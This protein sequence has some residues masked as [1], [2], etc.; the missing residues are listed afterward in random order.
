MLINKNKRQ[1]KTRVNIRDIA[2]AAG[3]SIAS[4]S[5]SL[6]GPSP[7][8]SEK[9]RKMILDVCAE[10]H[11]YPNEHARRM[12][13][14]MASS[15]A[16]FY[17]SFSVDYKDAPRHL[18]DVNFGTCLLGTQS[19]LEKHGIALVLVGLTQEYIE[20][21]SH[22]KLCR[23][24]SVDGI[25]IWGALESQKDY[26][27]ELLQEDFSPVLLQTEINDLPCARVIADDAA[28]TSFLVRKL[29]DSGHCRI[30]VAAPPTHA[31]T[32]R[33]RMH[34]I[35]AAFQETGT[36][37]Y[38]IST[39]ADYGY[40]FGIR[41]AEE[42]LKRCSPL[43]DAI[44][45]SN[46]NAAFGCIAYLKEHGLKIPEDISVVGADGFPTRGELTVESFATPAYEIGQKGA[47]LLLD[48]IAGAKHFPRVILPVKPV[49]GNTFR[50]R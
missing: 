16:M 36:Q 48:Q 26:I 30:A 24:K 46:D 29:L 14:R 28:G 33:E 10:M 2:K 38:F 42:I 4:V 8:L 17:P 20:K 44:V 22:L 7:Y 5:R 3:V 45:C 50:Q 19:I 23:G 34:G 31:S 25:L 21:K 1:M 11:Y 13:S 37:P 27:T 32:G 12:F 9:R 43:P 47:E 40:Q 18:L 49:H 35:L 6:K 39:E 15:V 41:C